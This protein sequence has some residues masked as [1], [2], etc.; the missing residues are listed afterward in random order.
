[1][2]G[3]ACYPDGGII[4]DGILMRL[5]KTPSF[6]YVQAEGPIYSWLIAKSE[7]LDVKISKPNIWVNQVQ[8]PLSLEGA[9]RSM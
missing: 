6:W 5:N 9:L 3:I 1:M 2:Y 7:G 4:V 8:G